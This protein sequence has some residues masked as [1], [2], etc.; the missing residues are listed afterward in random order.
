M[1]EGNLRALE[2][3]G[4]VPERARL[5]HGPRGLQRRR[6]RLGISSRTITR[7]PAPTAGTRTASPASA[8]ATSTSA[9]R[10]RLWNGRDPILKERLF[11]LTG[12]EGNH[13][14]DVKECYFYLDS[15]PTHSY[16]KYLYKYPQAA[17]PYERLVEENRER[18]EASRIRADRYRRLRRQPLLRRVRGVRQSLA[19]RHPGTDRGGEPRPGGARRSTCCR[20]CG[21]ATPGRGRDEAGAPN[22]RASVRR[23][24]IELNEAH[25]GR[26]W[27]LRR[28]PRSCCSPENETN[29][30]QR[31]R[32]AERVALRQGRHQRLRGAR[33]CGRGESGAQRHQGGGALRP[34]A[35]RG[36]DRHTCASG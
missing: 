29:N 33:R 31:C 18:A 19:R 12:N 27:L 7:A 9:S 23:G 5:G 10:S 28:Q 8:T 11:G 32:G 20:P 16:M 13:G 1:R 30:A 26:R 3:L 34:D 35:R 14:E 2:A 4:A 6:Q 17:F 36:R 21:S 15:T 24:A 25:Y 22:L